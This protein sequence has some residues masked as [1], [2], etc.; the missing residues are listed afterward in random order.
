MHDTLF[1][2][3]RALADLPLDAEA[4]AI[5]KVTELAQGI[6]LDGDAMRACLQTQTYRPVVAELYRQ[7]REL[8]V[9]VTPSF[10]VGDEVVLGAHNVEEMT[11]IIDR[12]IERQ[13]MKALG[14][15]P[16]PLPTV[17]PAAGSGGTTTPGSAEPTAG[18][19]STP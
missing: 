11:A 14:T 4:P 8:G 9:S 3:W 1:G 18:A 17:P 7:A 16:P 2:H 6:G 5:D 15:E 13:R 10:A 12:E 19:T